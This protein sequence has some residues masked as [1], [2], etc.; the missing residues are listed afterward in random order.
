MNDLGCDEVGVSLVLS[1]PPRNLSPEF[2]MSHDCEEN[3]FC[4]QLLLLWMRGERVYR[5]FRVL[6]NCQRS[7]GADEEG[8]LERAQLLLGEIVR[9]WQYSKEK[10]YKYP[11]IF[12]PFLLSWIL[13]FPNS[14]SEAGT[15]GADEISEF[16]ARCLTERLYEAKTN[17]IVAFGFASLRTSISLV[18]LLSIIW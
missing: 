1:R 17:R 13:Q 11:A 14:R 4:E 8:P 7:F 18:V 16:S 10:F 15:V 2:E 6:V 9:P 3:D 5:N 12:P